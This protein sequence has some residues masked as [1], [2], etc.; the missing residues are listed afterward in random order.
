M[1]TITWALLFELGLL[2]GVVGPMQYGSHLIRAG[3]FRQAL[4][5]L[6]AYHAASR[7]LPRWRGPTAG[8]V[9]ACY[10][11]LGEFALA[12]PFAEIAVRENEK[13]GFAPHLAAARAHLGIIL[14]RQG[15]FA[16]AGILLD[17][18]LSSPIPKRLRPTVELFA[19]NACINLDRLAQAEKL[20]ESTLQAAKPNSDIAIVALAN[21]SHC[22]L[23]QNR[24]DDAL[25]LAR[26]AA[27]PK[28]PSL[29]IRFAVQSQLLV[30]LIESDKLAEAQE[31]A[32]RLASQLNDMDPFR[33]G[34]ALRALAELAVKQG[35]WDR[36]RD[37][38]QR[39]AALGLNPNAHANTLLIQAEVFAAR[40][41]AHRAI[42][43]C[44]DV[45]ETQAVSFYHQRAQKLLDRLQPPPNTLAN[46]P[47]NLYM[48]E[49]DEQTSTFNPQSY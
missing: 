15:D 27:I 12:R 26:Q 18:T 20:L 29:P 47:A 45:L 38:A 19:A 31:V 13:Q 14:V 22:R 35:E 46:S 11:G 41:N 1:D 10:V 39:S 36:A 43:L 33:R 42:T 5:I 3:R 34:T 48:L 4:P 23:Y 2:T 6:R 40:H 49:E 32:A 44:Q 7:A 9:C 37:Y 24:I 8:Y 21:L 30:M 28:A 16:E 25:E 17:Q